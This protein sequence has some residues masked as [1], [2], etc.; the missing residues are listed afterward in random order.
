MNNEGNIEILEEETANNLNE[1][2]QNKMNTGDSLN[3]VIT[4]NAKNSSPVEEQKAPK[5]KSFLDKL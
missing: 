3:D 4:K 2:L 5:K 1:V